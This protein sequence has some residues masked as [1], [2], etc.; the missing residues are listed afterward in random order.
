MV[1]VS[2]LPGFTRKVENVREPGPGVGVGAVTVT[3]EAPPT[4]YILRSLSVRVPEKVWVSSM[5]DA[6]TL[7]VKLSFTPWRV[8]VTS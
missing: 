7:Y 3:L 5:L 2:V 6:V 4:S 1:T 8:K